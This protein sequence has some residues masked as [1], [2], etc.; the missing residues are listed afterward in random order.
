LLAELLWWVAVALALRSVFE[1]VMV[2]YYLWPPLAVAMIAAARDWSRLFP[3]CLAATG[4][5]FLAQI[6]WR[7][8][9]A[10]WVP[11]MAVLGLTLFLARMPRGRIPLVRAAQVFPE[12]GEQFVPDSAP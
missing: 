1:P 12:P 4:L 6:W 11:M 5:T 3:T 2:A 8:P 7:N 9:W 10:W